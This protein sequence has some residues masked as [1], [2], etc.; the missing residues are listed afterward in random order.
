MRI[1]DRRTFTIPPLSRPFSALAEYA[2]DKSVVGRRGTHC[3]LHSAGTIMWMGSGTICGF[4][5]HIQYPCCCWMFGGKLP[6]RSINP[7]DGWHSHHNDVMN[8]FPSTASPT[9]VSIFDTKRFQIGAHVHLQEEYNVI[10]SIIKWVQLGKMALW[11]LFLFMRIF[12]YTIL[13][14][15]KQTS[16]FNNYVIQY[17]IFKTNIMLT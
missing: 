6:C 10:V 5:F 17:Q 1:E 14:S 16:L 12:R 8:V 2:T 3:E 15:N 4:Q 9:P 13:S 7:L 11:Y